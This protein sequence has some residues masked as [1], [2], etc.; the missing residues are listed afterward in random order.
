[1]HISWEYPPLVYG[2]LGR[3]VHALTVAQAAAGHEVTVITQQHPEAPREHVLE[4]VQ[5]VREAP[6]PGQPFVPDYLIPW[7]TDLDDA[8]AVS[9]AGQLRTVH[10][11]VVHC[12]D[13]MTTRS[14]ISTAALAHV[15][16]IATIHATERGRHQGYLPG[17]IS[18]TVDSIERL[19]SQQATRLIT[20]S[21]AMRSE[22]VR[23]FDVSAGKVGVIPNGVDTDVWQTSGPAREEARRRWSRHGPLLVFTGRLEAEKGIFTLL[24][25]MPTVLAE[26]PTARLI[27]AGQGG[28]S[29][30]FDE[31]IGERGL[32]EAVLR[33]GW[34]P[35]A[36]LRALIGAADVVVIPSLYEPFGLVA[37]EA[38]ALGAP[39]VAAATGGLGD[40][41]RTGETGIA[42]SPGDPGA[43]AAA[44]L[45]V[46]RDQG[47]A[48]ERAIRASA[49]LRVRYNW[50][51]IAA[52]TVD[53]YQREI[54]CFQ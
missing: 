41:I 4:G 21:S 14:G 2:G 50:R 49:E 38:M 12:H 36:D 19:L 31:V 5:V 29:D 43:F 10:P 9:A 3:H 18:V 33:S 26:Q 16:L 53:L 52:D 8:L 1:M 44:V 39:V 37:L 24:D 22:V 23:Q 28:Q 34:L 46:L 27:V 6:T 11:E 7:V 40:I 51:T 25:A 20:C 35:E 15:P 30:R 48:R 32:G 54:D 13:W 17:H 45:D 42:V 47:A